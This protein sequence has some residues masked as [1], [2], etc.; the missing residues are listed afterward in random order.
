[1]AM[2]I[3]TSLNDASTAR[4]S[5]A[6]RRLLLDAVT[7]AFG[8]PSKRELEL[9]IL[10]AFIGI[11]AIRDDPSVYDLVSGLRVTKSKARSLLYDRELR[12]Q[13]P[14]SLD[15][16]ARAALGSPLLQA[17]G[18]TVA[19]DIENPYLADHIRARIRELGHTTDGS[20]SPNLIRLSSDAAATLI[21]HYLSPG[22]RKRVE[23]VLRSVTG[24]K[25][26]AQTLITKAIS[27]AAGAVAGKA[28]AELAD[29]GSKSIGSLVE[30]NEDNIRGF[31]GKLFDSKD[32]TPQK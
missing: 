12:R 17:Q 20:F 29:W 26:T 1:M 16:L 31:F 21:D 32:R 5:Q 10:E 19:L 6:L 7:P 18:Y 25:G 11:G 27:A 2:D 8:S 15:A 22:D 13:T 23:R 3:D 14:E 30:A 9:T 24:E 4:V 28:G